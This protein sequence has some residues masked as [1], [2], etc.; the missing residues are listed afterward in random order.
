MSWSQNYAPL[1]DVF[2]AFVAALPVVTLLALLAFWHVRAHLA[3]IAGL[4]V[5]LAIALAI[6]RMPPVPAAAAAVYGAAFGLFPIGWIVLSAIF[7]YD[8]T[9]KTG[10]FEI[11]KQ[12]IAGLANDLR[13]QL[14]F[15]ILIPFGWCGRSPAERVCWTYGLPAWS[16]GCRLRYHSSSL[17]TLWAWR[18]RGNCSRS[19][20]SLDAVGSPLGFRLHMEYP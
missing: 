12:T 16:P 18:V 4:V 2:S 17:A 19:P 3:A 1:G 15:S 13:L 7:L 14:L 5:A 10:K 6:Y 11:I 8:I 9:N 20:Y